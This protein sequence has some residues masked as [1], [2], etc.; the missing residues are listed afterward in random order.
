MKKISHIFVTMFFV[1]LTLVGCGSE[2]SSQRTVDDV[3]W[4]VSM[5]PSKYKS[6]F[7]ETPAQIIDRVNDLADGNFDKIYQLHE[8]NERLWTQNGDYWVISFTCDTPG[9]DDV[10]FPYKAE[11]DIGA[12]GDTVTAGYMIEAFIGA[13]VPEEVDN[14]TYWLDIYLENEN[15]DHDIDMVYGDYGYLSFSYVRGKSLT[16][17]ANGPL[18]EEST[19]TPVKPK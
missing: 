18:L 1:I 19:F 15:A 7:A 3:Y 10:E 2:K 16:I 12:C 9:K 5:I 13:F 6:F 4:A 17:T 14:I 8:D 11:L